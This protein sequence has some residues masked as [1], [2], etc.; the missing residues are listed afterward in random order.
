[1]V[2]LSEEQKEKVKSIV[3]DYLK[4][5]ENVSRFKEIDSK[6]ITVGMK[7]SELLQ[8]FLKNETELATFIKELDRINRHDNLWGFT[9]LVGGMF[10]N[11]LYKS[12]DD[13]KKLRDIL[14]SGLREPETIDDA[15]KKIDSFTSFVDSLREKFEDKRAAPKTKSSLYFLSY[16][17]QI[18]NSENYP[19]FYPSL[20][21]TF[22]QLG[23]LKYSDN[24]SEYYANFFDLNNELRECIKNITGEGFISLWGVEHIFYW[25]NKKQEK[26]AKPISKE[27]VVTAPEIS[28]F[29]PPVVIDIPELAKGVQNTVERYK[30]LGQEPEN[31]LEEKL[32]SFFR[33]MGFR[34]EELGHKLKGRRAPDGILPAPEFHYAV[35]F[36]AKIAADGYSISADDRKIIEYIKEYG[37]KM[38]KRG[39]DKI[40]FLIISSDF[41]GKFGDTI[42]KIIKE[43]AVMNVLLLRADVLLYMLEVKLQDPDITLNEIENVFATDRGTIAK[44]RVAELLGKV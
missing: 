31:V 12:T 39:M 6:R 15:K 35:L 3:N 13:K 34:V 30:T 21:Q 27:I 2:K 41:I 28:P 23:I 33:M 32:W 8:N 4:D 42:S 44:E 26:E 25:L 9:G 38:R 36:D 37:G 11:M 5:I 7:I 29:L 24:L 22:T 43:T 14:Q 16:F 18:Q 40:Y 1:M 19:V 20:E 10:L 17:W